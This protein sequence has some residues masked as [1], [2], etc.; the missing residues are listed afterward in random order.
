MLKSQS[1][2]LILKLWGISVWQREN[3]RTRIL[4]NLLSKTLLFSKIWMWVIKICKQ[5]MH[6]HARN[7]FIHGI[8]YWMWWVKCKSS[9][10]D[11]VC[12][13]SYFADIVLLYIWEK[14]SSNNRICIF[15]PSFN[16]VFSSKCMSFICH[17]V[18]VHVFVWKMY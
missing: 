1:P 11:Q 12:D 8:V 7:V 15:F 18:C 9:W 2:C 4:M 5:H 10:Y 13:S 6:S 3:G 16:V 14:I 17:L